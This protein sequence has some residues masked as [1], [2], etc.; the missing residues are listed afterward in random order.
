MK[1]LSTQL[2]RG[3][4]ITHLSPKGRTTLRDFIIKK[5]E[6]P[7]KLHIQLKVKMVKIP[8]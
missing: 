2:I 3:K 4:L 5:H 1:A 8:L 6:A 7:C